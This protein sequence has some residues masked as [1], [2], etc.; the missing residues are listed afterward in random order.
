MPLKL[1]YILPK[2]DSRDA[3][4]FAHIHDF[5]KVVSKDIDICLFVEKGDPPPESLGY[6]KVSRALLPWGI[7]RFFET[8]FMFIFIR[9]SGYKTFYVHYSFSSAFAASIITKIF[10][11]KVFYWNCG[12]PWKYKRSFYREF[13]ERVTYKLIDHLV[14]GAPSLADKYSS[15]Y[16]IN[17]ESIKIMPNWIDLNRFTPKGKRDEVR[18]KIGVP[19]D[20]KLVLFVH[21]LSKRKGADLILP[22]IEKLLDKIPDVYI[23]VAGEGPEKENIKN[24]ADKDSLLS[25]RVK[26]LGTVPN[27]EIPG[28]FEASDAFLI[29]SREEGFPRVLLESWAM[30]VPAVAADVGA[31]RD[32]VP[33]ERHDF[34]VEEGDIAGFANA[35]VEA[36]VMDGEIEKKLLRGYTEKYD[37]LKAAKQFIGLF[38]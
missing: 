30:G 33:K 5:L 32:I 21:R 23:A 18:G 27:S 6:K 24:S 11:G 26:L 10:G 16:G 8:F 12:E 31:V 28:L 34:V 4:H 7:L 37:L 9:F 19:K 17:R 20:A 36:F 22:V 29:P 25:G 2:Y 14:T 3:T 1:C 13:F 15:V 38:A 35:L